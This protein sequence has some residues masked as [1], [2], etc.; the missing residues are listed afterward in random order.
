M[1]VTTQVAAFLL[2]T[3]AASAQTASFL[4]NL[5]RFAGVDN[6]QYTGDGAPSYYAALQYPV[7]I[8]RDA[9][10]PLYIAEA[11]HIRKIDTN[12]TISTIAAYGVPYAYQDG[13]LGIAVDPQGN[14]YFSV[15]NK[16]QRVNSDGTTA[17]VAGTDDTTLNTGDGFPAL[18]ASL[19]PVALAFDP[20][21]QLYFTDTR[22]VRTLRSDGK[23]YTVAGNGDAGVG[24]ENG[25]AVLA[26]LMAAQGL[27][28]DRAGNLYVADYSRIVKIDAHGVLTRV[29]GN[30]AQPPNAQQ[31]ETPAAQTPIFASTLAFGP[32]GDLFF[33]SSPDGILRISPDGILHAYAGK[34]ATR[35]TQI[36]DEACGD[37][38]NAYLQIYSLTADNAGN[39]YFLNLADG[40]RK[41]QQITPALHITTLAGMG[42]KLFNGDGLAAANTA[43]G[44]VWGLTFD[45]AGRLY[46]ADPLNNRIRMVD[47]DGTVRTVA[48]DGGPTYEQDP[49]CIPD[50]ESFLSRP[51][52]VAV[53]SAGALYIADTGKRRIRKVAPD[54]TQTTVPVA[55][56][57]SLPIGVA[58][59][60]AGNLYVADSGNQRLLKVAPSGAVLASFNLFVN[61]QPSLDPSG[62]LLIP[63]GDGVYRL[64][65]DGT[66]VRV[67][68]GGGFSVAMDA[69]GAFYQPEE[70]PGIARTTANCAMDSALVL[71]MQFPVG[72]AFD[73]AG[74]LYISDIYVNGVWRSTPASPAATGPAT[75][76]FGRVPA[77]NHAPTKG[78]QI[79]IISTWPIG[80]FTSITQ[81]P[82][83]PGERI[84]LQGACLGPFDPVTATT[85]P[86]GNWPT[87]L[88]GVQ[89]TVNGLPAPL[90]SVAATEVVALV[91]NG[92]QSVS[93]RKIPISLTYGGGT[94]QF[95]EFPVEDA[96][97]AIYTAN[98]QPSGPALAENPDFSINSAQNPVAKGSYVALYLNGTGL[99]T[100]AAV[101][102]QAAPVDPLLM[103]ALPVT[104]TVGGI[105][106]EVLFAGAAPTLVGVTQVNVRIPTT[107]PGTGPVPLTLQVGRYTPNQLA[108]TIAVQ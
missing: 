55:D 60:R 42:P 48:G 14:V 67:L 81:E 71:P 57:L 13:P 16:I 84:R 102:G 6:S 82:M 68:Q 32:S 27:A 103:T 25:P 52:S 62:R 17:T 37:A 97:P 66:T 70:W 40:R 9:A 1:P 86:D 15:Q 39:L 65:A 7:A 28:F 80:S 79:S 4:P 87:S 98:G 26:Q 21:G 34:P 5:T 77:V 41:L 50:N 92:A 38:R 35:A 3:L 89:A 61:G 101:D 2:G 31:L 49:A 72:L 45:R 73:P 91:P 11:T 30:P 8:A 90:L 10:G 24:G 96:A 19:Q 78:A 23:V 107:V 56:T 12:G 54:G 99:T 64:L 108:I 95:S 51:Q 105:P 104:V 74:N 36:F 58:V 85:A 76:A 106:A 59:D 75:P 20:Q 33:G 44:P 22:R 83:A 18:S 29:A 100:P 46:L 69:A 63:T 88:G 93:G 47:L 94:T 53:D 43:F